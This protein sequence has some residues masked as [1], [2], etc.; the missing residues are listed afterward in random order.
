MTPTDP[1]ARHFDR[2][3]HSFDAIYSHQTGLLQRAWNRLT[4]QNIHTRVRFAF[5]A[6]SPI[7]GKQIL[8]V[9]CGSGQ[10][11]VEMAAQGAEK[12]VGLDISSKMIEL[13][14]VLAAK[15]GQAYKCLFMSQNILDYESTR[16]FDEV[17]ALGFF[18]YIVEPAPLLVRIA[19]LTKHQ[20]VASFPSL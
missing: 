19:A 7:N 12:V 15:S 5:E 18:D 16:P 8:D 9:G 14:R 2:V 20:V 4:R 6:L 11:P 10:Y 13:A 17:I 3:A 1:I